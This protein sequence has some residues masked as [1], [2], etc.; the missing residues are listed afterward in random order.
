M[1]RHKGLRQLGLDEPNSWG[2]LWLWYGFHKER[3]ELSTYPARREHVIRRYQPA[4]EALDGLEMPRLGTG[5][6]APET[7]WIPVDDQVRQLNQRYLSAQTPEDF[8]AVGLLCRDILLSLGR[9]VFDPDRHVKLG[10]PMPK[11]DDTKLRIG[12][13]LN[14]EFPGEEGAR[15]RTFTTAAWVFVQHVV[16]AQID[17][18]TKARLAADSTVYIV[19]TLRT[20]MPEPSG[21]AEGNEEAGDLVGGSAWDEPPEDEDWEPDPEDLAY[22][23]EFAEDSE[24]EPPWEP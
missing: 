20:L 10:D 1:G 14:A 17:T 22:L 3:P 9:V 5:I 15:I 16:H 2:D 11:L 23:A 6:Q 7:G 12:L 13:M 8:R 19:N 21:R 4:L 18:E 24:I